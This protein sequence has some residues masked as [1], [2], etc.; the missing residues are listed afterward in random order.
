MEVLI[1]RYA[2]LGLKGKNRAYFE[3]LLVRNIK[4]CLKRC[5]IIFDRVYRVRGRIIVTGS[6]QDPRPLMKVFGISSI[7][8]ALVVERKMETI[9]EASMKLASEKSFE[10]FRVTSQRLD[11]N[12][13][14]DSSY[15]NRTVGEAIFEGLH[16]KV[17]LKNPELNL[18]IEIVDNAY[19]FTD[20][21]DGFRGLP[22]GCQG[23]VVCL[24]EG[25]YA[26]LASILVMRR[27]CFVSLISK[28][29]RDISHIEL[30]NLG[31]KTRFE[32]I[33]DYSEIDSFVER[34]RAKAVVVP[35]TLDGIKDYGIK[36][37]VL[38]PLIAY[39]KEELEKLNKTY[40]R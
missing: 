4:S 40:F 10:S 7:S 26:N 5:A 3:K 8:K 14:F 27:G 37:L 33:K 29:L 20:K 22:V 31:D 21:L 36:C 17:D 23:R 12:F 15:I 11:K 2:E 19:L 9:I 25:P 28:E 13:P 34:I 6:D 18:H 35:D 38:R 32:L 1:V 16:K 24:L 30:F 39:N